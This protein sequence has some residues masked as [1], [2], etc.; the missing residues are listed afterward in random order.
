M[1][2]IFV[3]LALLTVAVFANNSYA[4][5]Q[6]R[7]LHYLSEEEMKMPLSVNGDFTPPDPPEGFVRNV[8]EFDQMQAVLIRYPFGV[9]VSLI[10]EIAE[11]D[12][13]IT[14][15]ANANEQNTVTN[16]YQSNG[17]DL[18]RCK[19]MYAQTDSYWVRD[20]GPWFVFDGNLNPGIV[21]F[22][23]NRPRPNDN[24]IPGAVAAYLGIDLYGMN[25]THT[26]GNYMCSG[27]GQAASTDL[28]Y[29]EN[30]S[31]SHS[32]I[33]T[34]VK[35]YLGINTYHVTFD[36]LGEYIKHIDCWGKFLSPDK[37][38]IGQVP[39]SD[40]R[41]ND[42]EMVASYFANQTS[43]WG[44][45]YKVYRVYSPGDSPGT[46]YTN[47]LILNN[48]V[49]VPITGSQWDN[50]AL[51]TYQEAMPGYQIIGVMYSGWLNTDALHCRTKGVADLKQLYIWHVPIL[52][53]VPFQYNYPLEANLYNASGENIYTDSA[54][55][56]YKINGGEWQT[57][58][59]SHQYGYYWNGELSGFEKGDT[60]QYYIYAADRAGK[61]SCQP[62]M[63]AADPHMFIVGDWQGAKLD[64]I[65][66]TV[67]FQNEEQMI[68]GINLSVVNISPDT[69]IIDS[70]QDYGDI[71]PWYI[72]TL[73]GF[74]YV[75]SH[76]DTLKLKV[77]CD[78]YV[79]GTA[80]ILYDTIHF[81][82]TDSVYGEPA[83]ANSD[84]LDN[85]QSAGKKESCNV[86][87]NPFSNFLTFNL[88]NA[89]SKNITVDIYDIS[90]NVLLHKETF[91]G[92]NSVIRL[93]KNDFYNLPENSG[94]LIYKIK[95]GKVIHTGKILYNNA[96]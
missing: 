59:L 28:V 15:V 34:L 12:T 64:F 33:D 93:N 7:K 60:V 21:D 29:D 54:L 80:T 70:I 37:I 81:Y 79:K 76:F 58:P 69:V 39:P 4:Q 49:Y 72:D 2:K 73:P 47:S 31:Y 45:K 52:G 1:K 94:V 62:R 55:V 27:M 40:P 13:V 35:N 3:I 65:P 50:T 90:G 51:Q 86:F 87:P 95:Y 10:K 57:V 96:R 44:D 71:F 38:L 20:Y 48:K 6:W 85:I 8:A 26:G 68:Y 41:Y 78:F 43:S 9:P 17:V 67:W 5:P 88:T 82:T 36:P 92:K 42:Y 53:D 83:M 61:R 19:F 25:L 75:L 18:T 84:L 91:T 74:P 30:P 46:P 22:P 63:G 89:S 77:K 16:I 14:I 66:D 23:Y 32:E 11:T 56:Y 24:N